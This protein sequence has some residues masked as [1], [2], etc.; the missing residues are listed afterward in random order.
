MHGSQLHCGA[1]Q[2]P[3]DT[4]EEL[5]EHLETCPA[6]RALLPISNR[7]LFVSDDAGHTMGIIVQQCAQRHV[8]AI[9]VYCEAV[10]RRRP[11]LELERLF[12]PI[13]HALK[14]GGKDAPAFVPFGP[15]HVA[16]GTKAE[17]VEEEFFAAVSEYANACIKRYS[18]PEARLVRVRVLTPGEMRVLM[19][20][21]SVYT[22]RRP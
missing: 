3:F 15:Q 9:R 13:A 6:A 18:R 5:T 16:K 20:R 10:A 17:E 1:C 4:S 14:F 19:R 12:A 8:G 7:Y 11:L 2:R 21:G 22:N